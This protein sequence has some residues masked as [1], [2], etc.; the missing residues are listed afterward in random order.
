MSRLIIKGLTKNIN[1]KK[2]LLL[3]SN[4]GIITDLKIFKNKNGTIKNYFFIGFLEKSAAKKAIQ[5][6][7]GAFICNQK[8]LIEEALPKSNIHKLFMSEKKYSF[9]SIE[10]VSQTGLLFVRNLPSLCKVNE[11]DSLFSKFGHLEFIKM[12]FKRIKTTF[13]AYAFIKFSLPE[14]AI[15]AAVILDGKIF[16]GKILHIISG[17]K[18]FT[19]IYRNKEKS[20]FDLFKR[21]KFNLQYKTLFNHKSWFLLFIPETAIF[22]CL[23]SKF[24]TAT[25]LISN[26]NHLK[27]NKGKQI[28]SEGR[29]QIE[30]F[31]ILKKEGLN[32]IS[33]DPSQVSYRSNKIILI[34]NFSIY[35]K[36]D[37]DFF[38]V[39]IGKIKKCVVLRFTNLVI[40]EFEKKK[41][42]HLAFKI[43]Q[44]F[45]KTNKN[46]IVQ[47]APLKCFE[48]QFKFNTSISNSLTSYKFNLPWF[49]KE[50]SSLKYLRK[51][52]LNLNKIIPDNFKILIRNLP[53]STN[54]NHLK[55]I[56]KNLDKIRSVRI[57]KKKNGQN[58]GFGFVEFCTLDQAKKALVLIQNTHIEKRHLSCSLLS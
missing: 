39:N 19:K 40:I 30:A 47:W 23:F 54:S 4:Y 22:K 37:L 6:K 31:L 7:N 33:F 46:V 49:K 50:D 16:Q 26:Y 28:I 36:K 25:N 13:S 3:F 48:T 9:K 27:I 18:F 11:L 41:T 21:I 20:N 51:N 52:I 38:F 32:I 10:N 24:G 8:I 42:A 17:Y 56:F 58:R 5:E 55:N 34:K 29:L 15:N 44:K 2:I 53:F 1:E 12:P 57:P 35:S 14:C 45:E 43:V